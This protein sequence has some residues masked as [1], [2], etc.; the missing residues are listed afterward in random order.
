MA[1]SSI[2]AGYHSITPYL[3]IEGAA[4]AIGWYC[5]ALGA[6]EVMRMEDGGRIAHA[7]IRIGDSLVMLSDEYAEMD[8]HGPE[9]RGGTTVALMLYVDDVDSAFRRAIEAGATEERAVADQF[10]GDRT[11]TLVD[12]FGHRWYL[13]THVEDVAPEEMERRMAAM[14]TG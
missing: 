10:Y 2:P 13:A 6:T 8:H 9:T 3:A 7:E 4:E 11:G 1:T 5:R 14:T 12:P